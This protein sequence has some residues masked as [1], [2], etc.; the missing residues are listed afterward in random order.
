MRVSMLVASDDATAGSVIR[1]AERISPSISGR[2]HLRFC[3]LVAVAHE[4][5]HVAGIGRGAVEHFRGPADVAHLLG[6]QRVFQIGQSRAAEFIV[7]VRGRRHEHVPEAF[8]PRL[9]LQVLEDRDHLPARAFLVLLL[10]DRHR[11]PDMRVHERL[12]AVEPFFLALR[13]I[14]VHGTLLTLF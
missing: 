1:K 7:L 9:L 11:G 8:G 4:H 3:S 12:H 10:V 13:H 2:S 14:E 5:F 6:E